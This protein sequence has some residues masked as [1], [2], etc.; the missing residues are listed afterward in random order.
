MLDTRYHFF[1]LVAILIFL[2]FGIMIGASFYG[3]AQVRQQ[4]N[5]LTNLKTQVDGAVQEGRDAK[6]R[7]AKTEEA[8]GGLRPALVRGR[9]AGRRVIV[10]QTGDDPGA[11]QAAT[12][13][14]T[15]AG[16]AI[17]ATVMLT[18]RWAALTPKQRLALLPDAA[19]DDNAPLLT[20]LA[21]AL[22]AGAAEHSPA[23]QT[24]RGLE[25]AGLMTVAGGLAQPVALFVLVGG[26]KA[27]GDDQSLEPPA[28]LDGTLAAQLTARGATV[29]GCEP[30]TA[31]V[32]FIPTYQKAGIATI[33]CIDLP[34]GQLALPFALR[35]E[36]D[37]FGLKPTA[38]RILPAAL[39]EAATP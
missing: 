12:T 36:R 34:L 28:V 15:D 31:A 2:G 7:L 32:S 13:A 10:I 24:V 3:E 4:R 17:P 35:G 23:A 33:D 16:A 8:L 37:D 18:E 9:L 38:R 11:V 19:A 14:L 21:G 1:Y 20:A 30:L 6:Q 39:E 22:T 27:T 5:I 29:V 25:D 26:G